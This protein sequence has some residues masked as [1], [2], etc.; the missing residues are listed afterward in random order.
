MRYRSPLLLGVI[1]LLTALV[2]VLAG[3]LTT[4][5]PHW[6]TSTTSLPN[7]SLMVVLGVGVALLLGGYGALITHT[8]RV[9][10]TPTQSTHPPRPLVEGLLAGIPALLVVGALIYALLSH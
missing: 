7:T 4:Q 8:V 1:G 10:H 9:A 5:R 3:L 6:A 2:G